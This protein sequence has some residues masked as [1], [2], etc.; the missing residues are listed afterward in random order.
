LLIPTGDWEPQ[1]EQWPGAVTIFRGYVTGVGVQLSRGSLR[2]TLQ[3]IHWLSDL[4]FSSALSHQSHPANPADLSWRSIYVGEA[5]GTT[6]GTPHFVHQTVAKDTFT[7]GT[8]T[9]DLW[10]ASL[11]PFLWLL[12]GMD[13]ME[14]LPGVEGIGPDRDNSQAQ[15]ALRRIRG[16]EFSTAPLGDNYRRLGLR[17]ENGID[18]ETAKAIAH[19]LKHELGTSWWSTTIWNKLANEFAA[20]F[21][22]SIVPQIEYAM[23]AP[24]TPGYRKLWKTIN[25]GDYNYI[26]TVSVIPR[27]I[28]AV[29]IYAGIVPETGEG[30]TENPGREIGVG[31]FYRPE[32]ANDGMLMVIQPS[33]WMRNLPS[34]G[35]NPAMTSFGDAF[36]KPNPQP[37]VTCPDAPPKKGNEWG[38]TIEQVAIKAKDMFDHLARAI[39]VQEVLRGRFGVLHGKLRFD[40]APGSTVRVEGS[41]DPHI[42]GDAVRPTLIGEVH[43]VTCSLNAEGGKAGTSCQLVHLRTEQE[44]T[45]DRTSTD[46]HPLYKEAFVGAPLHDDLAFN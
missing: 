3:I 27:P 2:P 21:M 9:T 4:N 43:R 40:I 18:N 32:G 41:S 28:K 12:T 17:I 19:H 15:R 38:N 30:G 13:Q 46:K 37:Q 10:A 26:D 44:N 5:N 31:G 23:V 6:I 25:A 11:H 42:G 1:G 16:G 34:Y 45:E 39:Y 35:E 33:G 7:P 22:Y 20:A 8:V 24:Y 36:G 14:S 29:A